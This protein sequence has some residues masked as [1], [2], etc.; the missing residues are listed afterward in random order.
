MG[1]ED[2]VLQS[3]KVEGGAVSQGT[4]QPGQG[5][6]MD[7]VLELPEETSPDFSLD[8]LLCRT[9]CWSRP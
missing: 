3:L 7:S 8:L 1:V 9:V 2:T 6:E 4:G 5:K